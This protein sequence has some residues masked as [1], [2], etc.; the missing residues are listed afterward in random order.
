[1]AC[2]CSREK[3][4]RTTSC[5]AQL[6]LV[7]EVTMVIAL[8]SAGRALYYLDTHYPADCYVREYV[9]PVAALP[10]SPQHNHR[11]PLFVVTPVQGNAW[12]A[13]VPPSFTLGPRPNI[14]L[15]YGRPHVVHY[16]DPIPCVYKTP[17]GDVSRRPTQNDVLLFMGTCL[18]V[19][20]FLFGLVAYDVKDLSS[21][22]DGYDYGFSIV[23]PLVMWLTRPPPDGLEDQSQTKPDPSIPR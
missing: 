20:L 17:G 18:G 15:H 9:I 8:V 6:N 21:G 11:F 10:P 1:M 2:W 7:A 16:K 5:R 22:R 19:A 23:T 4:I 14:T 13:P 12:Y 3:L